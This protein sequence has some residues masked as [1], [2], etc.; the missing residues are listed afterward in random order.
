MAKKLIPIGCAARADSS[1][2]N[3][4][5]LDGMGIELF[6]GFKSEI[7]HKLE[8]AIGAGF[9]IRPDGR[10]IKVD[11]PGVRVGDMSELTGF[12]DKAHGIQSQQIILSQANSVGS[13]HIQCQNLQAIFVTKDTVTLV[14]INGSDD[15]TGR[16]MGK[17]NNCILDAIK[18]IE[19]VRILSFAGFRVC[20][21]FI[22]D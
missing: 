12:R 5:I 3:A 7:F 4:E 19:K 1:R 9:H 20:I 16:M 2:Y 15:N 10:V 17:R 14:Q 18:V 6:E 11:L 21:V 8:Q 22:F 13:I